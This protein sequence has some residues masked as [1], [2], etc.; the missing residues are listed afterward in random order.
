MKLLRFGEAGAE[1][2]GLLSGDGDI[3]DLSGFVSE[4]DAAFLSSD[5][6]LNL[7]EWLSESGNAAK[8]DPT[9]R[10]GPPIPRPGKIICVGK[11]YAE[12]AKETHS[13]PPKEPMLFSKA[14]TATSGP[15]D[16]IHLPRDSSKTDWEVEL[17]VV[18]GRKAKYIDENEAYHYVAGYMILNDVSE[19]AF[20]KERSGQFCKGKSHDGFAPMGPYLVTPDEVGDPHTLNLT[21][22]LNGEVMQQGTTADMIFKVPFLIAYISRFMTLMPGDV[23]ATGT[24]AGVGAGRTP[25]RFLQPGDCLELTVDRLGMQRQEILPSR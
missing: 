7:N 5:F 17:A 21:L 19:R 22:M 3:Y 25:P 12:H 24:P 2:P 18:I 20:Q 13:E 14:T 9:C 15:Y 11:N 8:A 4:F 1:K 6:V 16:G 23:L 10:I